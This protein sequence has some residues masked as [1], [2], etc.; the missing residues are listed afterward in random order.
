M[1]RVTRREDRSMAVAT[2]GWKIRCRGKGAGESMMGDNG[3][4]I[5][6]RCAKGE[7]APQ[8]ARGRVRLAEPSLSLFPPLKTRLIK[9][10]SAPHAILPHL[11]LPILNFTGCLHFAGPIT[12]SYRPLID[13]L[14]STNARCQWYCTQIDY[15]YLFQDES[16]H[17]QPRPAA[18]DL[19]GFWHQWHGW[20]ACKH[21]QYHMRV[22]HVPE[23]LHSH[24]AITD[25]VGCCAQLPGVHLSIQDDMT[26]PIPA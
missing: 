17:L 13:R 6:M 4:G 1:E 7:V 9:F 23:P 24:E 20:G 12:V 16:W 25:V 11:M 14:R 8:R 10:D 3:V 5:L 22:R 15:G 21:V 26:V 2:L 19:I 18:T